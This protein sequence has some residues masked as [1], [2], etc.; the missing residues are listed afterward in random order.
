MD[1]ENVKIISTQM[2]T[3]ASNGAHSQ[4]NT[5]EGSGKRERFFLTDDRAIIMYAA[6]EWNITCSMVEKNLKIPH[7]RARKSLARLVKMEQ[8]DIQISQTEG[9][10]TKY[11]Y[12]VDAGRLPK[13]GRVVDCV[14]AKNRDKRLE[15]LKLPTEGDLN[16]FLAMCNGMAESALYAKLNNNPPLLKSGR[17]QYF[18]PAVF[19]TT[20]AI[21][22]KQRKIT[23]SYNSA[24]GEYEF[25]RT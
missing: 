3:P 13:S 1:D 19:D 12:V 11:N 23:E 4:P 5:T 24:L 15:A 14:T 20:K 10:E 21:L 9:K 17:R 2:P 25:R 8:L 16:L 18:P 6:R 7:E 22:I